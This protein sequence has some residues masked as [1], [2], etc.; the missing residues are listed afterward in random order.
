MSPDKLI[1][2]LEREAKIVYTD[3]IPDWAN[4]IAIDPDG[5]VWVFE[6]DAWWDGSKWIPIDDFDGLRYECVAKL[7]PVGMTVAQLSHTP[8]GRRGE[9][10]KSAL[11]NLDDFGE[12]FSEIEKRD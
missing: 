12:L 7:S 2:D 10:E 8:L 11:D 9:Y 4:V 1:Q 5:H 6:V 3:H